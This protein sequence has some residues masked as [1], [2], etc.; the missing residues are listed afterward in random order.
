VTGVRVDTDAL[1]EWSRTLDRLPP[2]AD[3][4]N[5]VEPASALAG[6]PAA[7]RLHQ[8]NLDGLQALTDVA[9][10]LDRLVYQLRLA[11]A[12]YSIVDERVSSI[13]DASVR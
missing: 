5:A 7:A 13:V 1:A 6:L 3:G 12:N 2:L 11:T 4:L 10:S 9:A 8:A